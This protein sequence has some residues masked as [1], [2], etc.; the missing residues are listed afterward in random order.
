MKEYLN[1][2]DIIFGYLDDLKDLKRGDSLLIERDEKVIYGEID[3]VREVSTDE[4][5]LPLMLKNP[6]F[7]RGGSWETLDMPGEFGVGCEDNLYLSKNEISDVLGRYG[8]SIEEYRE[9]L[10]EASS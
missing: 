2:T 3:E 4:L 1:S 5:I 7:Y 8:T 9:A 10:N 6:G